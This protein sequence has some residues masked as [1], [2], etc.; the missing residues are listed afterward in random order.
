M[1]D[2]ENAIQLIK[3]GQKADAQQILQAIIK[4]DPK[5]IQAWFWYVETC[6]TTD[7]RIQA[8][9]TCLKMNP[10]NQQVTNALH[11]LRGQ[12]PAAPQKPLVQ[13]PPPS[14]PISQPSYYSYD[15]EEKPQSNYFEEENTYS[16]SSSYIAESEPVIPSTPEKK[17]WEMDSSEYVDNSMLA[18]SKKP[19]RSYSTLDVWATVLTVQDV[20]VYEDILNDPEASLGRAFTW[21]AIA[22]LVNALLLPLVLIL[23]PGISE[24]ASMPEFQDPTA[25]ASIT[26]FLFIFVLVMLILVPIFSVINLAIVGGLQSFLSTFFGGTGNYTRTVY[27]LAAFLSP[28][29]I[30]SSLII[31]VPIVGQCLSFPLAIYNIVLN[32]RALKAAHF[33]STGAALGAMFSPII[34]FSIFGCLLVLLASGGDLSQ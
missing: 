29:T 20:K 4:S 1:S 32:V 5:N 16:T 12:V 7:Q 13:P 23:N 3:Q 11:G 21:M 6:S 15:F 26:S 2:L 30:L 33:I 10:G 27:A 34:L 24:L 14:Q 31:L 17:P 18:K 19:V 22:G 28:M 8:L 25:S 9:E